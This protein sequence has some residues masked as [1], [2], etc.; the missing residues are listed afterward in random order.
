[1]P[2]V[3]DLDARL[4]RAARLGHRPHQQWFSEPKPIASTPRQADLVRRPVVQRHALT[5]TPPPGV[6]AEAP[7]LAASLR[8][9]AETVGAHRIR[10]GAARDLVVAELG[11][12][13][14]SIHA[15]S[16]HLSAAARRDF[17]FLC[18]IAWSRQGPFWAKSVLGAADYGAAHNLQYTVRRFDALRRAVA[19]AK[20]PSTELVRFHALEAEQIPYLPPSYRALLA[21][22]G[23]APEA[24]GDAN[25]SSATGVGVREAEERVRVDRMLQQLTAVVEARGVSAGA[26]RSVAAAAAEPQIFR[27][28]SQQQLVSFLASAWA[29]EDQATASLIL[30]L[31]P[32][33]SHRRLR[34]L[35]RFAKAMHW[36]VTNWLLA[37]V[38]SKELAAAYA[39]LRLLT[40]KP[41][42]GRGMPRYAALEDR[43]RLVYAIQVRLQSTSQSARNV[44]EVKK[45]Y[46]GLRAVRIAIIR[47]ATERDSGVLEATSK[48]AI[49]ETD[50]PETSLEQA[51][52][53]ELFGSVGLDPEQGRHYAPSELL[54]RGLRALAER[55][56]VDVDALIETFGKGK[57]ALLALAK[58]PSKVLSFAIG[59]LSGAFS[60]FAASFPKIIQ[61]SLI[62]VILGPG[63]G[64][65]LQQPAEWNLKST[66][67][68]MMQLAGLTAERVW[69]LVRKMVGKRGAAFIERVAS[70]VM[71]LFSGKPDN[72]MNQ[73]EGLFEEAKTN[74]FDAAESW[75]LTNV[76]SRAVVKLA[77][78][79]SPVGAAIGAIQMIGNVITVMGS[80]GNQI[81]SVVTSFTD[82]LTMI[83]EGKVKPAADR[84]F[85]A[86]V[87]V[88]PAIMSFLVGFV[89]GGSKLFASLRKGI[90]TVGDQIW[91][92]VVRIVSAVVER[93]KQMVSSRGSADPSSA[94]K[95]TDDAKPRHPSEKRQDDVW[96]RYREPI[97]LGGERHHL[98]FAGQGA[99]ARLAVF[100]TETPL[101]AVVESL[102]TKH[103]DNKR[104]A[105]AL[106][107]L[108]AQRAAFGKARTT[109]EQQERAFWD[110]TRQK[111]NQDARKVAGQHR[112]T[113]GEIWQVAEA[114]HGHLVM[115]AQQT[116]GAG[117]RRLPKSRVTLGGLEE[118]DA[119]RGL[120]GATEVTAS[121][122]SF[123]PGNTVG[124]AVFRSPTAGANDFWKAV[125]SDTG[126]LE[127][128]PLLA[129]QLHGPGNDWRNLAI[130]PTVVARE[131]TKAIRR[132]LQSAIVDEGR[133]FSYRAHVK[134]GGIPKDEGSVE[135]LLPSYVRVEATEL[136]HDDKGR[137]EDPVA[138]KP[139][140]AKHFRWDRR[141]QPIQ[142]PEAI[143]AL[144]TFTEV[145]SA[146]DIDYRIGG[147]IASAV[148]GVRKTIGDADVVV[149]AVKRLGGMALSKE[150]EE[151]G[152]LVNDLAQVLVQGGSTQILQ[153]ESSFKIDVMAEV[154]TEADRLEKQRAAKRDLSTKPPLKAKVTSAEDILVQKLAWFEK[155]GRASSKQ[156]G[157]CVG[158]VARQGPRLDKAYVRQVAELRELPPSVVE[159]ALARSNKPAEIT[160]DE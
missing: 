159:Q 73:V 24:K 63:A 80:W 119:D 20:D 21:G 135:H 15:Q 68:F 122:L 127:R 58:D 84:I 16:D 69:T 142:K 7:D 102:R 8:K 141:I 97:T 6:E 90:R 36:D 64:A 98:G 81:A 151:R 106:I 47:D 52:M 146:F 116:G 72:L 55:A 10:E 49:I 147:G 158:I 3:R 57:K 75:L 71:T 31:A 93:A 89:L 133:V 145:L 11:P 78:L 22:W 120:R 124:S 88:L 28:A 40:S 91:K 148:H 43:R 115:I 60:R 14:A 109:W 105:S 114:I 32:E 66:A 79:F 33:R 156:W 70:P 53:G 99:K 27:A 76:V 51:F 9:L 153:T 140:G 150:L 96:W 128:A 4:E 149:E 50:L 44:A 107:G 23:S 126:Y 1:M 111:K 12:R 86:I 67:G 137:R 144:R 157:D 74:V 29:A 46:D 59:A 103:G 48:Q 94:T 112:K 131:M 154:D 132:G 65:T 113:A 13:M 83:A 92:I 85:D 82:S 134:R 5:P 143:E 26:G 101:D 95:T 39:D 19:L 121:P 87:D 2:L 42:W 54:I 117:D 152:F 41:Y 108:D 17:A 45:A 136:V 18:A 118:L 77:T 110:L 62:S 123:R 139:G 38:Q 155:G 34:E 25:L 100:S 35:A 129:P 125:R 138:W 30:E 104:V 61:R 37:N 130:L 160:Y 56:G